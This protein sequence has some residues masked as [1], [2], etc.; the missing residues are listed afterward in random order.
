M[1]TTTASNVAKKIEE[2]RFE[3]VLYIN[4]HIVCQRYFNIRDYNEDSPYSIEIKELMDRLVGMNNVGRLGMI[5]NRL[6]NKSIE[7]L[8]K[9]YNSS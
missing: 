7:Y 3:F 4:K 6:K 8:W 2:Q 9:N 5:P 1:S